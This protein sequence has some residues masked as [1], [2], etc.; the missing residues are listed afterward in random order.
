MAL[1]EIVNEIQEQI[2]E[3][4]AQLTQYQLDIDEKQALIDSI[5]ARIPQLENLK[6]QAQTISDDRQVIVV[7]STPT[8]V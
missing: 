5:T 7:H 3:L 2:D 6:V 1:T 4:N 8:N